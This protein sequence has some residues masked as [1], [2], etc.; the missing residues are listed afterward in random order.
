MVG[1]AA[2]HRREFMEL[3][4]ELRKKHPNSDPDSLQQMAEVEMINRG[5][6]S[7]AFYRVQATRKLVGG[8]SSSSPSSYSS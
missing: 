4:K 8:G 3:L 7:R 5:P 1:L 2:E 6:K